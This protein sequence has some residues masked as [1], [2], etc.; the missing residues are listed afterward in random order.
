MA[1]LHG[2]PAL[3]YLIVGVSAVA[4]SAFRPA[5]AA[6]TPALARTPEELTA[7]NVVASTIESV[8]IF[9]GPAIGG[10][11]LAASGAGTVF[12]VTAGMILWSAVLIAGIR[13]QP[14]ER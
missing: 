2:S 8:G 3:I 6:L 13:P 5:E 9:G 12:L 1:E 14:Q 7:A 4:A 11:L 10:L